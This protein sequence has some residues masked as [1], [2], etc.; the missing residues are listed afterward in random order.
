M[1]AQRH[2][3]RFAGC[4]PIL[5]LALL[6]VPAT[7]QEKKEELKPP[8]RPAV[9]SDAPAKSPSVPKDAPARPVVRKPVNPKRIRVFLMDGSVIAGELS[10]QSIDVQ[11]EFGKLT[12][13]VTKIL[14]I[15]PGLDSHTKLSG[16]IKKLIEG[17]GDDDY[18]TREQSHK[19]LLAMGPSVRDVVAGYI[20]DKNA[21]RQRHAS[22][23]VKKFDEMQESDADDVDSDAGKSRKLVRYD[24]VETANFTIAGRISPSAFQVASKYGPLK[25]S[26]NDIRKTARE[27]VGKEAIVKKLTVAGQNLVLRGIKNSGIRISAGD[28]ISVSATGQIV[29]SPWGSTSMTGPDGASNYGSFSEGGKVYYGGTLMARVGDSGPLEKVG[30]RH[31]WVAKKSGT[32]YFGVAVNPSYATTSYYYPGNYTLRIKVDPKQ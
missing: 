28:T 15:T 1:R 27:F 6:T 13:P 24:V 18:K 10:V 20:D 3:R 16:Q 30:S 29:M 17:L 25:V 4:L 7:A 21:E 23:I 19:D 2:P 11:T 32:L 12:V 22:E 14:S 9:K 26:L 8:S 5:L 31:K